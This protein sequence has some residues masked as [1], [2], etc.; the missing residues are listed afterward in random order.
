MKHTSTD[1]TDNYAH[2]LYD[3]PMDVMLGSG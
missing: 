3:P 1:K 2:T